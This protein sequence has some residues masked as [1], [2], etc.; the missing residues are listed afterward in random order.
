MEEEY[1]V[2]QSSA[3]ELFLP[4]T[5]L[6]GF[7]DIMKSG[8]ELILQRLDNPSLL[9][10]R[11][12][13]I[14]ST[15][16]H[17]T[18]KQKFRKFSFLSILLAG[19]ADGVNPCA[20]ATMIFLISFLATQKRKRSEILVIGLSFT[21]MVFLTY[22]LMGIGAFKALAFLSKYLWISQ[23]I[24][25]IAVIFAGT[26][27]LICFRDAVV[28][29]KTGKAKD[30]TLQLPKLVKLQIHKVISGQLSQSGLFIGAIISG[31][32][33]TLLEAVC[34]G[35]V[36]LP[37]IVLMTK[38]KG[39]RL[40]GWMYLIIYNILF[41]L[42]LLIIMVMAYFGLTWKRLAKTTQTNLSL[43]KI[44]MGIVLVLLA[45]FLALA[46]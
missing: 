19:L 21:C 15:Q 6:T 14:D 38:E 41:I 4:D 7:D 28:Y 11:K 37:T 12:I 30:I 2:T 35:Q 1:K 23:T 3:E 25:W 39:L 18:L 17:Q 32:L 43:L 46:I 40:T 29:K 31:F 16:Y 42:P 13:T 34:T 8:R 5:F 27:S 33:V 36:Y 10:S 45:C 44:A 9:T 24:K 22:M 26:V 20:I